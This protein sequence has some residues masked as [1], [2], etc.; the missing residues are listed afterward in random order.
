MLETKITLAHTLF[1]H[2]NAMP[3]EEILDID[4]RG[5]VLKKEKI[6]DKW[7]WCGEIRALVIYLDKSLV[8]CRE[9]VIL[10]WEEEIAVKMIDCEV[11][12]IEVSFVGIEAV[13]LLADVLELSGTMVL[14]PIE[15][16]AEEFEEALDEAINSG[17]N[18]YF[19]EN[20][21]EIS[22][23]IGENIKEELAEILEEKLAED[24]DFD[25]DFSDDWG[26]DAEDDDSCDLLPDIEVEDECDCL[27]DVI[28]G[29]LPMDY[30]EGEVAGKWSAVECSGDRY[31]MKFILA[32]Q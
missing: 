13:M 25:D 15:L 27:D 9:E 24:E 26:D 14:T 19:S 22:A 29:F 16:D 12:N 11:A 6:E 2:K 1:L 17:I 32:K 4:I 31:T 30:A 7:F 8:E 21:A 23:E 5:R 28:D 20:G 18:E 3:M 10:P